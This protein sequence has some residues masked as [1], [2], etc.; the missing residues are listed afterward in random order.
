MSRLRR[1]DGR[2]AATRGAP[3]TDTALQAAPTPA[4]PTP[5]RTFHVTSNGVAHPPGDPLRGVGGGIQEAALPADLAGHGFAVLDLGYFAVPDEAHLST[6]PANIPIECFATAGRL[7][8]AQPLVDRAHITSGA[9]PAAAIG[10]NVIRTTP[11]RRP[12]S[13]HRPRRP[14][15]PPSARPAAPTT[16]GS[17]SSPS[18]TPRNG[19]SWPS[20]S[21]PP[22]ADSARNPPPATTASPR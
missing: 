5:T 6:A 20:R 7:P 15:T 21:K 9:A 3:C 18:P 16:A 19:A 17:G 14:S 1:S 13:P 22:P 12:R 11:R 8:A 10:T 2:G 4:P